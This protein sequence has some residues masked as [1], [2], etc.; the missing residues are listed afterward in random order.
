MSYRE[1]LNLPTTEF[2]MKAKLAQR[3]PEILAQWREMALYRKVREARRGRET[4]ILHDGPPYANGNIHIGH[5]VNKVLKDMVIKSRLLDGYDTPFV[6]GWDCHGLPIELEVE[7]KAG[8]DVRAQSAAFRVACREYAARQVAQQKEDFVRLGVLADW[9]RPYLSM[10]YASEAGVVRA[11]ATI[12][13]NGYLYRGEHPVHWCTA[14]GSALAEAE[15]EY[16]DKESL[17]IDVRFDEVNGGEIVRRFGAESKAG[18]TAAVVIW[19]TTPWTL[20]ANRAVAVNEALDYVLVRTGAGLL[21]LA[22]TLADACLERYGEADARPVATVRG[23]DLTGLVLRHPLYA[24]EVKVIA[25]GHVAADAGTG[26]VH[27]APAHGEDDYRCGLKNKLPV[28]NYVDARGRFRE[29]VE[30]VGGLTLKEAEPVITKALKHHNRLLADKKWPHSYPHCW[31]HKT[32]LLFRTTPQWFIGVTRGDLCRKATDACAKVR[33]LPHWGGARMRGMLESRPDWCLSRQRRWGVPLPLFIHRDTGEIHPR[34]PEIIEKVA[35]RIEKEGVQVWFDMGVEILPDDER[36]H[37][38]KVTDTLDVWFDSGTTHA[39]VLENTEGLSQ[40]ADLYLEGSD[41]HRGWFQSSLLSAVAMRGT[42]PYRTVLTHGFTVDEHGHKMSKSR[43]N[44]VSPQKVMRTHGADVLRLWVASVDFTV[45][46]SVSDEIL[47]RVSDAYRRLRN[48]VRF[49]LANIGDFTPDMRV[50][51]TEMLSLDRYILRCAERENEALRKAYNEYAFHRIYQKMHNFCV[52]EMGGFYLD[53]LKDRLYTMPADSV[54]RRSAQTAMFYL[55]QAFARWFAPI[56]SFTAEEI[57]RH[58]PG[59]KEESVFLCEWWREFGGD[60]GER[61]IG[62]E[63]W[64]TIVK[65]RTAVCRELEGLRKSKKIGSSLDAEVRLF[66]GDN[67]RKSLESLGD[68]LHFVFITSEAMVTDISARTEAATEVADGIWLEVV[69]LNA[70]R[71]ER[72]WH[73][74]ESLNE[75]GVCPRCVSNMNG[76]GERRRHA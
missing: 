72:C 9:E 4:F 19:T 71:C 15:V 7:K 3:E 32:P 66:C 46:M 29:A 38:E 10:D 17:A 63:D 53:I 22:E 45:E 74:T 58:L 16:N 73:R 18:E 1:T 69:A 39:W 40:P 60:A 44:V 70:P 62:D 11:L 41:Q 13:A 75:A 36:Q 51:A 12:I 33:W 50:P 65:V 14:C 2:P 42:A 59:E 28:D 67:E 49:L 52:V 5:A 25:A 76:E 27:I 64:R 24:R 47:K 34:T 56:L 6:P 23:A 20:P 21:V 55:G 26:A 31:R 8:K 37:Y 43:G 54:G 68:E 35:Q 48:T 61:D 57:Y 30:L